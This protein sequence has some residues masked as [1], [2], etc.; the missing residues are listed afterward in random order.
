MVINNTQFSILMTSVTLLNT[1]LALIA[2]I[3]ADDFSSNAIGTIRLTLAINM[4]IF[5]G[6]LITTIGAQHLEFNLMVAGQFIFGLGDCAIV[7]FQE[8]ILSRWFR[9]KQLTIVWG[10]MLGVARLTKFVAKL[11][12]Y[13]LV[14]ATGDF[15]RPIILSMI[16][17]AISVGANVLYWVTMTR[18]GLATV[19]GKE[20]YMPSSR[21]SR[22]K[23][24]K[25]QIL[26]MFLYLPAIYWMVPWLQLTLSSVLSAFDDVSTEFVQFEFTTSSLYAGYTSSFVQLVPII[27]APL[28]GLIIDK[29]GRR[30]Y[31]LMSGG[32]LLL[33]GLLLLSYTQTNPI[34]GILLISST[35]ALGSVGIMSSCTLLLPVELIGVGV[36]LKKSAN[37]V[38]STIISIIVGY[39]QDLTFHDGNSLDN[40]TDQV[41]QY[42]Y[43]MIFFIAVTS[44]SIVLIVVFWYMDRSQLNGWLQANKKERDRRLEIVRQITLYNESN[45][46]EKNEEEKEEAFKSVGNQLKQKKSYM[47][48]GIYGVWFVVSWVIFF[49]F[50]LMPIY[51]DYSL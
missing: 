40:F 25:S 15:T 27:A 43:V 32:V 44:F 16:F 7:T 49:V 33:V 42:D 39:I 46:L 17:C 26:R 11:V 36:G 2:G 13:P 41:H 48:V 1:V 5:I 18:A 24:S 50:A 6:S 38:G 3:F 9:D 51:Q 12:C 20:I 21:H 29:F 8:A 34:V 35:F 47:Y 19:T 10:L 31:L 28:S 30:L 45:S 23:K 4:L 22:E 37:N 14:N